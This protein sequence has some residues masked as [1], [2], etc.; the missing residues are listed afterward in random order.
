MRFNDVVKRVAEVCP[1]MNDYALRGF[2]KEN[3]DTSP[4][5]VAMVFREGFKLVAGD[6]ELV[7]Y[8]VM[9]PEERVK[10][11]LRSGHNKP[12]RTKIPLTVSHLRLI[13]YRV[14]FGGEYRDTHL[15]TP[16]MF[17]DMLH[18]R[19]KPAMLRKVISEQTFSRINENDRDG[20]SV[21][22]IRVRV[23][24]N[25]RNTFRVESYITRVPYT[26]F[27]VTAGLF[28]GDVP[29]RICDGTIV[30]YMLAKF[31][32]LKTLARFG[33]SRTDIDFTPNIADD[34]DEFEYFAARKFERAEEGPGLF[35]KVRKILLGEDQSL[36]FVVN[37]LYVLSFFKI[38]TMENVYVEQG[39]VWKIILGMIISDDKAELLA[40]TKAETNLRSVDHFIDPI[41]RDRFQT[42]GVP[43]QDIYD[44]L[45]YVFVNIDSFMVNN[46]VQDL[47]NSRLAVSNGILVKSFAETIY[48][49]IYALANK[50][51]ITI[52]DIKKMLQLNSMMFR[53]PASIRSDDDK[54]Y[55]ATPT[56]IGD[57]YLLSGGLN[58]IRLTGRPEQRFHPSMA[59]AESVDGFSGKAIGRTGFLNPFIPTDKN[60]AILH[61]DYA[62]QIDDI[63]PYLPR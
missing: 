27:I 19:N 13:R 46:Q 56:I 15:Y 59:V 60:A 53:Q 54:D 55:I 33:L 24:F 21:S 4:D 26:K 31:G 32:F 62:Q 51:N 29:N 6:I 63:L 49:K 37:L 30:H 38:Q 35:L 25:R 1:T 12:T 17:E 36:K 16:Y 43:I 61:P 57:N 8:T 3:I 44:L 14:R 28:H 34:T 42:F 50:S 39:S 52:V 18:I 11:E 58:K 48:K 10:F 20:M 45:V 7:E 5:F 41:T 9:N 2:V 40:Y 22:P 23:N 47:Y